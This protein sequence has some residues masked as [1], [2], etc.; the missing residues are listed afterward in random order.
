M[1]D[2]NPGIKITV[3]VSVTEQ[4]KV[5]LKA[6]PAAVRRVARNALARTSRA[7]ARRVKT[8]LRSNRRTGQLERAEGQKVVT[9]GDIVVGMVGARSG[10]ST[11]ARG[12]GRINPSKYDHLVEKGRTISVAK[13]KYLTLQF[14]NLSSLFRFLDKFPKTGLARR[15]RGSTSYSKKAREVPQFNRIV[16]RYGWGIAGLVGHNRRP[17]AQGGYVV[18]LKRVGP[19]PS[20][21]PVARDELNFARESERAVNDDLRTKLG[22]G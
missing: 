10:F 20:F 9:Y 1:P 6:K 18:F 16:R 14:R 11:I 2:F 15:S 21:D 8:N 13:K 12:L 22:F 5:N 19:G 3:D 17:G 7:S 4:L